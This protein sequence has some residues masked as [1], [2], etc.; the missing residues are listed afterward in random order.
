MRH[1]LKLFDIKRQIMGYIDRPLLLT[2][3]KDVAS[4]K[5][6]LADDI[7]VG[8]DG[9]KYSIWTEDPDDYGC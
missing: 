6:V 7:L 2:L 1:I 3:L 8:A 5:L 9:E 4:G